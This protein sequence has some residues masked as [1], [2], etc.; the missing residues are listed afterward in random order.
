MA[1]RIEVGDSGVVIESE[2]QHAPLFKWPM[3]T[4]DTKKILPQYGLLGC[5]EGSK[6]LLNTNV[7]FSTFICGVQGSGKSHTTSTI[8]ENSLIRSKH[9]GRLQKPLSALILSYGHFG[10]GNGFNICEATFLAAANDD[11]DQHAKKVNVLV[12][13][14]NY[15]AIR[16]YYMKVP[17]VTVTPFRIKPWN[18]NIDVM[19]TLMAVKESE[20]P[21]LYMAQ[22]SQ[23]LREMAAKS[24]VF[25]Y[26]EFR[27]LVDQQ[28][29]NK[30]QKQMLGQRLKLLDWFLDL[31]NSCPEPTFHPG[32]IT[33]MD[34]SCPFV[35]PNTACILF[36]IGVEQYLQSSSLGK[37]VVLDEAH[38]YM[39]DVPG[40]KALNETMLQTI[41]L[42]RHLGARVII[43]TQE[44]TLLT[45]LIALC[46]V[47]VIHRFT[48]P[49]WLGA[50]RRH[51]PMAT[52]DNNDI[53]QSI[54]SLK[55]GWALVYSSNAVLDKNQD[56][57][58]K[59]G[60][61]K[62][63]EVCVRSRITWDGGESILT[64]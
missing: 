28:K 62:L 63:L 61:G 2:L 37:M 38:K 33:I 17:N 26:L 48:S 54:E 51:I 50:L 14:S 60:T 7:P 23:I 32:E 9:L 34:M 42:Q 57:S 55:T 30:V 18:L 44:P 31:D 1:N 4:E 53:M 41:R 5:H 56:G 25:N 27:A 43:S 12:S 19:L 45:D 59:K 20:S 8:L 16:E 58:L 46:S 64:A 10:S 6:L 29:F 22:V 39:L 40:A 52:E 13:P 49:E 24:R 36:K 11:S 15:L 47:T 35:D 21:P 3:L